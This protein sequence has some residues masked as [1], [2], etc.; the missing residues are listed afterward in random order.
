[1]SDRARLLLLGAFAAAALL[2]GMELLVT[3]VALPSII[4]DL[5]DWT[6]LRRASWVVN[7]YLVAYIAVMPL[8][9]RAADRYGLPRSLM[10]ALL[11]FAAGSLLS[12]AA[13][14]LDQLVAA[15]LLQGLGGGAVV[16][17]ATAGA[18]HLFS[19]HGRARALGVVGAATFLGMALG[20]FAGAA[21]LGLFDLA[22]ALGAAGQGGSA[23][24]AFVVPA[25]RWI[26]YLGAPL[27]VV[28]ALVAWAT[29]PTWPV[30]A[31]RGRLDLPGA[32][33]FTAALGAGLLALTGLGSDAGPGSAGVGVAAAVALVAGS[34]AVVR[35]LRDADPFLDL[36]AFRDRVFS[37]A[38][39]V[40]LLTG[41]AL[42]TA[43]IGG[44]VFVDRVHYGGPP[45]QRLALGALAG[46]MAV[47]A[48]ASGFVLRRLGIVVVS[49]VGLLLGTA[50]LLAL[51]WAD[52]STALPAYAAGL[53]VFGLGFGLSVTPR[54]TAAVEALGRAAFGMASA[55]VTVARM[56]GMGVGLAVLT[57]FGSNRIE[58]LS[59]VLVDAAA[60][61]AVLPPALRGRPLQDTLVVDALERWAAGEAAAILAGLFTVAGLI[62]LLAVLPALLM[63]R[64]AA[65]EPIR[66]R[67]ASTTIGGDE[68]PGL[69][70]QDTTLAL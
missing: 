21:V 68:R 46:A 37:S 22:P 44:A 8:A 31:R 61:D 53:A 23:A 1:M 10:T 45:D 26:F 30:P 29:G 25:W 32:L 9:G 27:A 5:A 35:L 63:R 16:P 4:T 17:L 49:L 40:S 12:G 11:V 67:A 39:L 43:I 20:P 65:A 38:V 55:A 13:Q 50:S 60:R 42:A 19:G 18:S 66:E 70:D 33:L 24:A 6:E 58:A 59:V 51:T 15:R 41:Y 28:V 36:R 2:V 14:S 47:G 7:G 57:A 48:L 34:L 64:G 62:M 54:S 52:A 69:A 56:I 3:A